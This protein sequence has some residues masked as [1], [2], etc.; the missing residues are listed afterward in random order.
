MGN[1]AA[2]DRLDDENGSE[3]VAKAGIA[4]GAFQKYLKTLVSRAGL[5]PATPC[6]KGRSSTI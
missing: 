5:E 4:E 3:V 6:L 1:K 2:V